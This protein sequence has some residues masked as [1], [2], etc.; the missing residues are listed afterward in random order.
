MRCVPALPIVLAL[1]AAGARAEEH[2]QLFDAMRRV[3]SGDNPDAVGDGGRARGPYQIQRIYWEDACRYGKLDW[4]YDASVEDARRC[5]QVMRLYWKKYGA[6]SDEER[7]R[8][9]NGG[10]TGP[11]KSATLRYWAKVRRELAAAP[12]PALNSARP[13]ARR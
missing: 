3:E 2:R 8:L 12:A 5:E 13:A 11:R 10:P 1:A 7:A 9:H 4:S 6:R